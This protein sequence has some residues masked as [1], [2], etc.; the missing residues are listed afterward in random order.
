MKVYLKAEIEEL[1]T[2]SKM[3]NIR[4]LNRCF[5]DFKKSYHPRTVLVKDEKADLIADRHSIMAR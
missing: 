4:D 3:N 1:E 5:N 2:N